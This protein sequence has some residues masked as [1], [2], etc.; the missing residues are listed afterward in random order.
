MLFVLK[1]SKSSRRYLP[2]VT[3]IVTLLLTLCTILVFFFYQDIR[4][5][6]RAAFYDPV[7]GITEIRTRTGM[8][9]AGERIFYATHPQIVGA[10]IFNASC[11]RKEQS[12]PVIGCYTPA[13]AIYLYNITNEKL[14]GI[15]EV[16]AVHE[17]LHAVWQRMGESERQQIGVQLQEI[18]EQQ[19]DTVL[20]DRM[21]YYHMH[22]PGQ[23]LNE[24][25]SIVGTELV[26]LTP[27]LERH[28]ERY[29][30]RSIVLGLHKKYGGYYNSL[31]TEMLSVRTDADS[32][33]STITEKTKLYEVQA[34][35]LQADIGHFNARAE[36]GDF[37]S[38]RVFVLERAA[39]ISRQQELETLRTEIN[40]LIDQHG[41]LKER[42]TEITRDIDALNKSIDSFQE[43]QKP[44]G[45]E[46]I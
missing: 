25:H 42:Y 20:K 3:T 2:T 14:D 46:A 45:I 30:N 15:K 21:K 9:Q 35:Q 36:S 28:Y 40:G 38:Q 39:L 29:F 11:P 44:T 13:D 22:Q 31:T 43:V 7:E 1:S 19:P 26:K 10:D 18:Y 5:T 16:T 6:V 12:S 27:E 41:L 34:Q 32:I 33:A 17:L 37:A 8:T 24:L 23:E 4:D